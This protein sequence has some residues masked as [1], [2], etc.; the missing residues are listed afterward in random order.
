M[1]ILVTVA[2]AGLAAMSLQTA[3]APDCIENPDRLLESDLNSDGVITRGEL[4]ERR[5]SI[6]TR[7]DRNGD[8]IAEMADAPRMARDRFSDALEPLLATFDANADG[9]LTEAEFV[10]GPTPGFDRADNNE[11]DRLEPEE[12]AALQAMA[13]SAG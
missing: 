6:F 8:G 9:R 13:C 1:N 2:I 3:D 5:S 7:L 12:I 10:D 11:N 4:G